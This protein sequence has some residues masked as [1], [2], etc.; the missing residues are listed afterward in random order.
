MS[1]MTHYLAQAGRRLLG[2]HRYLTWRKRLYQDVLQDSIRKLARLILPQPDKE[3]AQQAL[4]GQR[5]L[6]AHQAVRV[7]F[8]VG[9]NIG[10]TAREYVRLFPHA[11]IYSFEPG[12][13][14][15]A[16]L[17]KRFDG[18]ASVVAVNM[19]VAARPGVMPL[20]IHNLRTRNSLLD[21][22]PSANRGVHQLSVIDVPVTN[23]DTFCEDRAIS[24]IDI[25]KS[26]IEGADL[27]ALQ[28]A[29]GMLG[30]QAVSLVIVEVFFE[31]RYHGQ[32]AYHEVFAY[33]ASH[34]YAL[35]NLYSHY[36]R[37]RLCWADALFVSEAI[38]QRLAG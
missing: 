24:H 20:H 27:Y 31:N 2:E 19:A 21:I 14:E 32:G 36:R 16:A 23:I 12:P 22:E 18:Q 17:Q 10:Q 35:F 37:G 30:R 4:I 5:N 11:T 34:G 25:L 3:G 33:L 28:G 7:I 15:F 13:D 29:A 26:D 8:D 38:R 6:L 1:N 9:A